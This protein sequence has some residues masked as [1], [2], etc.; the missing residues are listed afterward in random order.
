MT[1]GPFPKGAAGTQGPSTHTHTHTHTHT[2]MPRSHGQLQAGDGSSPTPSSYTGA[3][4]APTVC[5][6]LELLRGM[7]A[8]PAL[9]GLAVQSGNHCTGDVIREPRGCR[10]PEEGHRPRPKAR[11]E[12]SPLLS[13][14]GRR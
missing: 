13:P 7:D 6:A 11:E 8:G 9:K 12:A 4:R 5:R 2:P 3:Y 14:R 1:P 10:G